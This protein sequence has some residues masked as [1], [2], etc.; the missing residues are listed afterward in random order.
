VLPSMGAKAGPNGTVALTQK[1]ID[2]MCMNLRYWD[3][4]MTVF[5]EPTHDRSTNLDEVDVDPTSLPFKVVVMSY[6]DPNLSRALA[7]HRVV[8]GALTHRQNHLSAFCRSVG[9]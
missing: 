5:M 4:P 3:V 7:R 9:V 2:G 6:D 1:F 8:L